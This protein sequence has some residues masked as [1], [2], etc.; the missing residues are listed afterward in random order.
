M[1]PGF[2]SGGGGVNKESALLVDIPATALWTLVPIAPG[3]LGGLGGRGVFGVFDL[4]G[5]GGFG[6]LMRY[7]LIERLREGAPTRDVGIGIG[8][9]GWDSQSESVKGGGES[10]FG[11]GRTSPG[12]VILRI[13]CR[14]RGLAPEILGP[15]AVA[16]ALSSLSVIRGGGVVPVS[17]LFPGRMRDA[18]GE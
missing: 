3:G 18:W 4:G 10:G 11:G 16:L 7:G 12:I 8:D 6:V 13:R 1:L 5:L 14:G 15:W 9:G 17:S 2:A